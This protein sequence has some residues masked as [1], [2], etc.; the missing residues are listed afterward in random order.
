MV[1][2][3]SLARGFVFAPPVNQ[4]KGHMENNLEKKKKGGWLNTIL[5]AVGL[6]ILFGNVG[7]KVSFQSGGAEALGYNI[8]VAV[9]YVG[10]AFLVFRSARKMM[11]K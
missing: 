10:G 2:R 5:L 9:S 3:P 7:G 6:L 8:W 4:A 11:A 1:A